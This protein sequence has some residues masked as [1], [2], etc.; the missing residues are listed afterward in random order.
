M[1]STGRVNDRGDIMA[2]IHHGRMTAEIEGEFVVF[3]IGMRVNKVWKVHR[4][5]PV[6]MAMFRMLR[7][8]EAHPEAGLLGYEGWGFLRPILVQYWRSYEALEN[9]AKNAERLHLPAWVKYNRLIRENDAVG[10]WHETYRIAPG[11]HEEIY[12][13]MPDF[14]LARVSKLVPVNRAGESGRER[15]A[16]AKAAASNGSPS[17]TIETVGPRP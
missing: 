8:L 13:N 11:M 10:I 17:P 4:W 7:E 16:A 6:A 3:L 1:T 2:K 5:V 15:M 12:T 9:Y 14:G